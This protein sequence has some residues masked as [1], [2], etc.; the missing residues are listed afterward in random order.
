MIKNLTKDMG[1]YLPGQIVPAI[2]G[3]ISIPTSFLNLV[4]SI[5]ECLKH[6]KIFL[7]EV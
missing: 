7:R 3:F 5:G 1:K 6:L 4:S 2:E